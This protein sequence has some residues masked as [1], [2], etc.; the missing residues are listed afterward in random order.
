MTTGD[1]KKVATLEKEC[2]SSPWTEEQLAESIAKD[3]SRFLVYVIRDE[4]VG[5]VGAYLLGEDADITNVAVTRARR[6]EGVGET[7]MREIIALLSSSGAKYLRLECRVSNSSA[8]ALYEKLGFENVGVRPRFYE[9]NEDAI[10][11]EKRLS[12]E[13]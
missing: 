6:R 5:Y 11:F 7:L 4:V 10:M 1:L 2:F 8:I 13:V 3:Y 12:R 9:D